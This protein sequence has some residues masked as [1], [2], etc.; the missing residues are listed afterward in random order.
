MEPEIKSKNILKVIKEDEITRL[1]NE[2]EVGAVLELTISDKNGRI[3]KHIQ[4]KA[5]S[6]VQQFLQLFYIQSCQIAE[7]LLYPIKDTGNNIRNICESNL[8]F[9]SNA[10]LGDTNFGIMVGTGTTD[11]A[12]NDYKL[13]TPIAHGTG[14]G[15]LQYSAVTFGAPA[16][17]ST[18][19]QF[20]ITRNFAN[21][22]SGSVT[23]YEI[24]LYVKGYVYN[25]AYYFM[26]LRDVISGGISVGAGQTLTV[27]YRIQA[28]I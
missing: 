13:Q 9:A 3:V 21:G 11:P 10:A 7:R 8:S 12:I 15:Q 17:D 25:T 20:T 26:T 14:S 4:R 16:A 1:L 19:S 24:G 2:G 23:V 5:E 6:F 18:T 28:V 27:N 22:S